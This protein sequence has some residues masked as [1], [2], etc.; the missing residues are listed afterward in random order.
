MSQYPY[1]PRSPHGPGT[2]GPWAAGRTPAMTPDLRLL[3]KLTVASFALGV[4]GSLLSSLA[5]SEQVATTPG[6]AFLGPGFVLASAALG[7]GISAGL[8]ALVYFPLREQRQWAWIVGIVLAAMA[9][10]WTL[11]S[12]LLF[13]ALPGL[14]SATQPLL[15][16]P[17]A[18]KAAVDVAWLVVAARPGVRAALR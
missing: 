18:L 1:D 10:L 2:P 9:V 12:L 4:L 16:L 6:T 3:L 5:S 15:L 11:A 7:I 13:L 8:Y 14:Q 17:A